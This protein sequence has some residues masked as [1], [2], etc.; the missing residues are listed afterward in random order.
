MKPRK[1]KTE[2]RGKRG[3]RRRY[4]IVSQGW[5]QLKYLSGGPY[6]GRLKRG[7]RKDRGDFLG[8]K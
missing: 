5:V 3:P 4:F 2:G 1:A 6:R 8:D 7:A